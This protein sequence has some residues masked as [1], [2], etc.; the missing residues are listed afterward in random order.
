[1]K[2]C[3]RCV[4]PE[5]YPGIKFDELG[6]C[7]YCNSHKKWVYR[8]RELLDNLLS[9][10]S[11]KGE[12]YDCVIGVSG[13]R[14]SSY[15]LHFLEKECDLKIIAFTGDSGFIPQAAKENMKRMTD[16]LG[17]ELVTY[18]HDLLKRCVKQDLRAWLRRPSPAMIPMICSGCK[19][20]ISREVLRFA[21][22]NRIPLVIMN[23]ETPIEIGILKNQLLATNPLGRISQKKGIA[24]LLGLF[25]ELLKNPSYL[26]PYN[27]YVFVLEYLYFFHFKSVQKVLYPKQTVLLDLYRYITWDEKEILTT[28]IDELEWRKADGAPSTWRFDCELSYLKN[29]LLLEAI[30]ISE[31]HDG[32]SAM[33]REDMITQAEALERLDPENVTP[34]DAIETVLNHI[35]LKEAEKHLFYDRVEALQAEKSRSE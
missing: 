29:F 1:M 20:A 11:G 3:T 26:S 14:D 12:E 15:A 10:F 31:K 35:G 19:L 24:L 13:G 33:V 7:N 21:K 22:R 4:L 17:V 8:D 23:V 9:G 5:T 2:T 25:Y 16:I 28:I 27:A 6:I 30:G 34:P 18:N 32:M